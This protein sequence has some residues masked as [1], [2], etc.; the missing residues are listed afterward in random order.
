MTT[1]ALLLLCFPVAYFLAKKTRHQK[2]LLILIMIPF[3]TSQVLRAFA[4]IILLSRTGLVN[5]LL[6]SIKL[7][8]EPIQ[9]IYNWRAVTAALIYSYIPY[10]ILPLYATFGKI[11]DDLLEASTD[12]GANT[13]QTLFTVTI[14]LALPGIV[15]GVALVLVASLTDVL[16]S[17]L[18]GGPF[19]EMIS[20]AIFNIFTLGMNWNLGSAIAILVF[21][22][23]IVAAALTMAINNR[24]QYESEE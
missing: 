19:D 24:V 16:A 4:W 1:V 11:R 20:K 6:Q 13:I 14:P 8:S 18:L 17:T 22:V 23:L 15:T 3:W 5:E 7:I 9:L 10:M 21:A 12:L 2:V